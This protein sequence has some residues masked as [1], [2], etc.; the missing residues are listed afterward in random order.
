MRGMYKLY[1]NISNFPFRTERGA[2]PSGGTTTFSK[3]RNFRKILYHLILREKFQNCSLN[4]KHTPH[5]PSKMKA[6]STGILTD[7]ISESCTVIPKQKTNTCFRRCFTFNIQTV[8][9]TAIK[10]SDEFRK[11]SH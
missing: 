9:I 6:K 7:F 5:I 10:H 1:L 3:R 4:C 2:N 11:H 8:D